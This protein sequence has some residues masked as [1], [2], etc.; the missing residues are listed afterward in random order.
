[1]TGPEHSKKAKA[2]TID[3]SKEDVRDSDKAQVPPQ[4]SGESA[5]GLDAALPETS[6]LGSEQTVPGRA[7]ATK[8]PQS[9]RGNGGRR[10]LGKAGAGLLGGLVAL[11]G[12]AILQHFGKLPVPGANSDVAV[13]KQQVAELS[14]KPVF[15][16]SAL[17][18]A[19]DG[20]KADVS[21]LKDQVAQ[22]STSGGSAELGSLNEKIAALDTAVAAI[23]A[24]GGGTADP[25]AASAFKA[26]SDKVTALESAQPTTNDASAVALAIAASGLKAAIDRGGPFPAE[27][28]TYAAVAQASPDVEALRALA[29][30]GVPSQMDLVAGF[31]NAAT[32]MIAAATV[33]DPDASLLQ[34]LTDSAASLVKAR[35]V[36]EIQGDEPDAVVARM[37]VALNRG[38][39]ETVLNES[40]KLP[41]VS[42]SAGKDWLGKVTAR[43]DANTLVTRALGQAL[44][45][46][47]GKS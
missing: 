38:D 21:T 8:G 4:G 33:P 43:R 22:L 14:A 16:P 18:L 20:L 35:R 26:L 32:D 13:I 12:A 31:D 46:A 1:M 39:L 11:G 19:L 30:S 47:G 28:E 6:A 45:A 25:Q 41:E 29:G 40:G 7:S 42:R 44:A 34:R 23:S 37:E 9:G 10:F 17:Q 5:V 15:D 36:G 2:V 3:L 27:L 24:A